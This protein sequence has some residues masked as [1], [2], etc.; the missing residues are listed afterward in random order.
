[1]VGMVS[2]C[3]L[4]S[5]R[6]L[7]RWIFA[8]HLSE[9][10]HFCCVEIFFEVV[11]SSAMKLPHALAH[12]LHARVYGSSLAVGKKCGGGARVHSSTTA[13]QTVL[14]TVASTTH[15]CS[16]GM[17]ALKHSCSV[18][19]GSAIIIRCFSLPVELLQPSTGLKVGGAR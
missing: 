3:W 9:C 12:G 18:V 2:R 13:S 11:W 16:C 14:P 4:F 8:H 19:S 10:S 17:I 7:E 1:M 5:G 15:A 6:A